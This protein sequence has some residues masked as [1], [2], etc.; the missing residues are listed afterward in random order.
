MRL[1]SKPVLRRA[2]D[3]CLDYRVSPLFRLALFVLGL[4]LA[5]LGY[6]SVLDT[7]LSRLTW[8]ALALV[9]CG[10][11]LSEDRYRFFP[12][13]DLA[14]RRRF[15]LFPFSRAWTL[16]R[17]RVSS[18]CLASGKAGEVLE[19]SLSSEDKITAALL[20]MGRHPWVALV[21]VLSDGR[22]LAIDSGR[23]H[24]RPQL[25]RD[26]QDIAAALGLAFVD[27]T[28]ACCPD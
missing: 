21:L 24:R 7:G 18:L 10:A 25:L 6:Y 19:G 15:G 5:A 16:D 2:K 12:T 4:G 23:P 13:G 27:S 22:S 9:T 20:G 28:A 3:G 8:Y 1:P 14:L 17:A 26:G 11:A